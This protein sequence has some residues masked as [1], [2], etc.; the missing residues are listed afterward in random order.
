[1]L[2]PFMLGETL[3][4]TFSLQGVLLMAGNAYLTWLIAKR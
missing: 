4:R 2:T 3:K 1:M